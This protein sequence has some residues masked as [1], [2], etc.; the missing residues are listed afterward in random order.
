[1]DAGSYLRMVLC[2]DARVA[3]LARDRVYSDILPQSPTAPA[4]V[5]SEISAVGDE[6]MDGP[7]GLTMARFQVES[8][9]ATRAASKDLARAVR[10]ALDGHAGGAEG[11]VVQSVSFAMETWDYDGQSK[12][13][14]VLQDYELA[15]S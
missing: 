7:T 13:F 12:L 4:V 10:S 5:F 9:A 11:F 8:W 14:R 1:M 15:T 2:A 6:A 3:A